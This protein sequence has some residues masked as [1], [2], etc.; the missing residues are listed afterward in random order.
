MIEATR[1]RS[2]PNSDDCFQTEKSQEAFCTK[3]MRRTRLAPACLTNSKS[4]ESDDAGDVPPD[5]K[6]ARYCFGRAHNSACCVGHEDAKRQIRKDRAVPFPH[7]ADVA[8]AVR[9]RPDHRLTEDSNIFPGQ[10]VARGGQLAAGHWVA[11]VIVA[12]F[13]RIPRMCAKGADE[14]LSHSQQTKKLLHFNPKWSRSDRVP[15]R[16]MRTPI[17]CLTDRFASRPQCQQRSGSCRQIPGSRSISDLAARIGVAAFNDLLCG[18]RHGPQRHRQ[19]A[20]W[21]AR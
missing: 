19:R 10:T 2:R 11:V 6:R 5:E 8:R 17:E 12:A 9:R 14:Q 16:S 3:K 21:D 1:T 15:A 4:D 18:S 13:P 7:A 20:L